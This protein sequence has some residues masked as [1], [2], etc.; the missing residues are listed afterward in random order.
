MWSS[1]PLDNGAMAFRRG[2]QIYVS[3]FE[4]GG[5]D[6]VGSLGYA[7]VT[8]P[9][10]GSMCSGDFAKVMDTSTGMIVGSCSLGSFVPYS[11][12]RRSH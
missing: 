4:G 10:G 6:R 5:C 9:R 12:M 8:R 7:L 2:S 1:E 3:T 11:K